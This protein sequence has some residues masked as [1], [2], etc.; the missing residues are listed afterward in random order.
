[1]K[2]KLTSKAQI[3]IPKA[4]R[5]QLNLQEGDMVSFEQ[6]KPGKWVFAKATP[7]NKALGCANRYRKA[8]NVSIEE[9]NQA[10]LD[11]AADLHLKSTK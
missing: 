3:T 1:M 5:Q 4:V 10:I 8:R 6:E 7:H 2:T 11:R 9:M